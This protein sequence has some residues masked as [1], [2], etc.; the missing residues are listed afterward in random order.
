MNFA[1]YNTD[2]TL[3]ENMRRAEL[4]KDALLRV[5]VQVIDG[6]VCRYR[7][8]LAR[9][10]DRQHAENTLRAADWKRDL[11]NGHNYWKA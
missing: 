9:F 3:W 8:C 6:H 5:S 1:L 2:Q 10:H 11:A 4:A 7:E